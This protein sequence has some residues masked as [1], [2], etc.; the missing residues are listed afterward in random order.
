MTMED[1]K[2]KEYSQY[3]ATHAE[4]ANELGK[5]RAYIDDLETRR[6]DRGKKG[7]EHY[8]KYFNLLTNI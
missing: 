3:D 4:I 1:A 8:A 2:S 5:S 7:P 6:G